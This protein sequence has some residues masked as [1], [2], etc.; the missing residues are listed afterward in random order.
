VEAISVREFASIV[1]NWLGVSICAIA[2]AE[3]LYKL[4]ISRCHVA[5]GRGGFVKKALKIH[6]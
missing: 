5:C 6:T 2:L 4:K 1:I 3:Y